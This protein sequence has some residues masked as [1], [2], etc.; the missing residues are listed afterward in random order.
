M[1]QDHPTAAGRLGRG[2][3]AAG[4]LGSLAACVLLA[5]PAADA[6]P[7][8][9]DTVLRGGTIRTVD[10]KDRVA[11][12]LAIRDGRI[13]Y[14]GSDKGVRAYIGRKTRVR[15][16]RGRTV[17]PGLHDA[18]A[19]VLSGGQAL[20]RCDLQYAGLTTAE[21]QAQ[22]QACLDK[23]KDVPASRP[24]VVVGWYRQAMKPA[25]TDAT[26]ATL[27]ALKTDRVVIVQSTDGHSSVASS[28]ALAAA[29]ITAATADP[30][31][32]HIARDGAGEPTGILEDSAQGLVRTLIPAPT[33]ADDLEAMT[34]AVQALSRQGV[35]SVADQGAGAPALAAYRT[36]WRRGKLTVRVNATP[37]I[38][39]V[40]AQKSIKDGVARLLGLRKTY[41]TGAVGRKP[42]IRVRDT[43]E[44]S[45][46]GVLQA[47]AHTASM[48][49]P[50]FDAHG[51]ATSDAG[52]APYYPT[53][54]LQPLVTELV[55][56]G[57]TPQ[58]H[59]IGDRAVRH[60]LDVYGQ[61][62]KS[63]GP[64]KAR[65]SI[66]HAEV[67]DPA[68]RGRFKKLDVTPVMSFQWG[69]PAPDSIEAAK[70]FMGP[71]RFDHIEPE[72]RL[73]RAGARISYGSDWPVDA[74]NEWFA[75]EVGITRRNEP[76]SGYKGRLNSDPG[77][78]AK[79]AL[80]AIT[81]NSA[82]AMNQERKTG[83]LERGKLADLV[84]IDRDPVRVDP[85][86]ISETKVLETMVGGRVV[87]QAK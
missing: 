59:A 55:K 25:G 1:T 47:P 77:L 8:P 79:E 64:R 44:L 30:P 5:A 20:V 66:S 29:N 18:H 70:A 75:I 76:D 4:T 37:N 83:S 24:M 39:F 61:V 7:R 54:V 11:Q 51:G 68:D 60:T 17:V 84:V 33:A 80:R 26:R 15:Q 49:A 36:L 28:K 19:H 43:G 48:L 65:L 40:E 21:F 45:Q 12:A 35:T 32:G 38:P 41:E 2:R 31:A 56:N 72:G 14:V 73:Y 23:E 62:R 42:G 53:A 85:A 34:A 50:Y 67:V 58:I 46:D 3:V 87:Y 6:A 74:L 71:T 63:Y 22:I 9:A 10:A 52:P 16:L 13:V 27:D 78:P 57:F 82:Y 81:Y 86:K 69:K